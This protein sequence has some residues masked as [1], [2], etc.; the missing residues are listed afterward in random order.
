M[1]LKLLM[2]I[3]K[4]R[5]LIEALFTVSETIRKSL[6]PAACGRTMHTIENGMERTR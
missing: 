6:G 5:A 1:N 3:M 4:V 2:A